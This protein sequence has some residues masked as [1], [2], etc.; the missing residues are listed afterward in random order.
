MQNNFVTIDS[1]NPQCIRVTF[2]DKEPTMAEF[3]EYLEASLKVMLTDKDF[4][5][6]SD[7]S[8]MKYLKSEFRIRQGNFFKKHEKKIAEVCLGSAYVVPSV[9]GRMILNGVFL[10][11]KPATPSAVVSSLAEAE[12]W[13]SERLRQGKK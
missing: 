11:N 12:K 10:I 9:I 7:I 13:T 8:K 1:T 5:V 4:V 3:E 2:S 6:I